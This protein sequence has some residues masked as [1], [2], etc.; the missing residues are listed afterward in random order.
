LLC[1]ELRLMRKH[2]IMQL[3]EFS[4]PIGTDGGLSCL[5]SKRMQLI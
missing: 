2:Q 5:S 3:P 1:V 4:L